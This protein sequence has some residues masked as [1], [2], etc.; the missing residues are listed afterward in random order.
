MLTAID[1]VVLTAPDIEATIGFYVDGLGA[2]LIRFG[3][4]RTALGIGS[5][6]INVHDVA[7]PIAPHADRPMPGSLDICFLTDLSPDAVVERLLAAAIPVEE[8]PVSRTGAMGP[9]TSVYCRDPDGNLVE[10]ASYDTP[11]A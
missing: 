6:K 10:I 8:G 5:Q 3:N 9:I 2:R 7:A 4:G 1:H 11:G